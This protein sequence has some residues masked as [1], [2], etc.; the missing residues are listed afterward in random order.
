MRNVSEDSVVTTPDI[1][2]EE[3]QVN[4]SD[5]AVFQGDGQIVALADGGYAVVWV[6][7]SHLFSPFNTILGQKM[8]VLGNKVGGEVQLT[9]GE[10][11]MDLPALAARPG[12]GF[13]MTFVAHFPD[14]VDVADYVAVFQFDGN[15]TPVQGYFVVAVSQSDPSIAFFGDGSYLV[16]YTNLNSASDIDIVGW[17]IGSDGTVGAEF[18]IYNDTDISNNSELASLTNGNVV[19]VYQSW[20]LAST[21]DIDILFSIVN[22]AGD[23]VRSQTRISAGLQTE[24]DPSVAA[25]RGSRLDGQ[26]CWRH[27]HSVQRLQ[28]QR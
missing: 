24:N 15:L 21:T 11:D 2:K 27:R 7:A 4:T 9:V 3:T 20:F 13:E 23:I 26:L 12:G 19:A 10:F 1:W 8:D 25:L 17:V 6:D 18:E 22:S 14:Y 5:E 16:T 28:Q